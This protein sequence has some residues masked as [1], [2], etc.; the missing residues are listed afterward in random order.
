[1][2]YKIYQ[3]SSIKLY[4]FFHIVIITLFEYSLLT[5]YIKFY[6]QAD[7]LIYYKQI[8]YTF[9]IFPTKHSI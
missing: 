7:F 1:M 9:C 8:F 5:Q 4:N 6:F 2:N 3:L